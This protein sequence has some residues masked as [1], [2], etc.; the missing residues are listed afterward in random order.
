MR[1]LTEV[2]AYVKR[3]D[4]SPLPGVTF[5]TGWDRARGE[6]RDFAEQDV[7][8]D[9]VRE[10]VY[11]MGTRAKSLSFRNGYQRAITDAI[12]FIE[13]RRECGCPQAG[14][15]RDPNWHLANCPV[16]GYTAYTNTKKGTS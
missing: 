3:D 13:A 15:R 10:F 16:F 1:T 7:T 9:E 12:A 4:V 11:V 5:G 14:P 8:V 6:L 2:R